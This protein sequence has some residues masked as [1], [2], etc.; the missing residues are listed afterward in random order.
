MNSLSLIQSSEFAIILQTIVKIPELCS[1]HQVFI[2]IRLIF[3][4]R[5]KLKKI[6]NPWGLGLRNTCAIGRAKKTAKTAL[7]YVNLFIDVLSK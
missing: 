4:N 1:V 6:V 7:I 5:D 2:T 3:K